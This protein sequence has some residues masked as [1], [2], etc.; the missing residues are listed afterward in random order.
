MDKKVDI[1]K[2][3]GVLLKDRQFL[4][5][6]SKGKDFFIAPGGKVEKGEGVREA[7]I[8]EL[9][10]ELEINVDVNDLEEFGVF[11]ALAAGHADKYLQMDVF[12]VKKWAG[13]IIPA[14]EVE[15]IKWINSNLPADIKLGSIFQHDVLPKL[16][17]DKLID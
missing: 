3:A 4:I 9:K 6:R 1:H 16:K 15:E 10:E 5:S 7:L 17:S 2:A 8:R 12:I 14:S 11:Y 13:E